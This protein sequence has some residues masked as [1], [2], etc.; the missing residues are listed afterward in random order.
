[1]TIHLLHIFTPGSCPIFLAFHCRLQQWPLPQKPRGRHRPGLSALSCTYHE[2]MREQVKHQAP[3]GRCLPLCSTP[4]SC[5]RGPHSSPS[6]AVSC[7][8]LVTPGDVS[9]ILGLSRGQAQGFFA[10]VPP[11][12]EDRNPAQGKSIGQ[13]V[14]PSQSLMRSSQKGRGFPTQGPQEASTASDSG[15][16]QPSTTPCPG[17]TR[18]TRTHTLWGDRVPAS[19]IEDTLG[20]EVGLCSCEPSAHAP[21]PVPRLYVPLH[22]VCVSLLRA[23]TCKGL[24][25]DDKGACTG[26]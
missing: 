22:G 6:P 10:P 15:Q 9:S 14:C 23:A 26:H 17:Q 8:H 4:T 24:I 12:P 16:N 1:M 20:S 2:Q 5:H 7:L 19:S 18:G 3:R 11:H 25:C 21:P 13:Q